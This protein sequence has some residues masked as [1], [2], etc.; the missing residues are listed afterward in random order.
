MLLA[1]QADVRE[2]RMFGGLC[3]MAGGNMACGI[4]G[5]ELMVRVGPEAWLDV[6]SQPYVREMDFTGKPMNGMVY[7][8]ADGFADDADLARWIWRGVAFARSLPP[9]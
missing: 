4:V 5:D 8:G 2:V 3:F 6:L 9:K 1:D 7:V